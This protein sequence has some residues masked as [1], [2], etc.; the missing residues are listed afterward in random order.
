MSNATDE[1]S[2]DVAPD[3]E[4]I[5]SDIEDTRRQLGETVDA[6]TARLDIKARTRARIQTTRDQAADGLV[7]ARSQARGL[8]TR[9]REQA[10]DESGAV[11]REVLVATA[12]V[13]MVAVAITAATIR[14]EHR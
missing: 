1:Q 12:V 3:I 6:L 9:V 4:A 13:A 2:K 11:R 8:A 5:Q 7:T 10:T 14:K